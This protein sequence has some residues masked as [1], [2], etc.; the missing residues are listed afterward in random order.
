MG[1]LQIDRVGVVLAERHQTG[2]AEG[3]VL[4]REV[5]PTIGLLDLGDP[6]GKLGLGDLVG[7]G[8]A[9]IDFVPDADQGAASP[10]YQEQMPAAAADDGVGIPGLRGHGQRLV[11]RD[12]RLADD[13]VGV[14]GEGC[15][16]GQP[17][18]ERAPENAFRIGSRRVQH[19]AGTNL[20]AAA[21]GH[22]AGVQARDPA[23]PL[24]QSG[25]LH[26]VGADR[27]RG[28]GTLHECQHEPRRIIH[29]PVAEHAGA[30]QPVGVKARIALE[31]RLAPDEAGVRGSGV[32]GRGCRG[33]DP[34]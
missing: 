9:Q 30:G 8:L 5:E 11:A 1:V 26:V 6:G 21:R 22:V 14:T 4:E 27:A 31:Q 28:C 29:L 34:R 2:T 15:G 33:C 13:E 19:H 32:P 3:N 18:S 23:R 20:D 17:L 25:G 7:V 12:Q 16:W 24:D 10:G